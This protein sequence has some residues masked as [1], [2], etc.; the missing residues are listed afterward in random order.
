MA[1]LIP[2]QHSFTTSAH[3][4]MEPQI[5][6]ITP[7]LW[8]NTIYLGL[9]SCTNEITFQSQ[10]WLPMEYLAQGS[11][12]SYI[13]LVHNLILCSACVDQR[14][15][16]WDQGRLSLVLGVTVIVEEDQIKFVTSLLALLAREKV[17]LVKLKRIIVQIEAS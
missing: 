13:L 7:S 2:L 5:T 3:Y 17:F 9:H 10:P 15:R 1:H 6:I 12:A 14:R 8:Q 16:L 11:Q 4:Y